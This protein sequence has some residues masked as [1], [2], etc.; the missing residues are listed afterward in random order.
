WSASGEIRIS[1]GL[2]IKWMPMNTITVMASMT[3]NA[4]TSLAS[5]W[6][7]MADLDLSAK[8]ESGQGEAPRLRRRHKLD[9]HAGLHLAGR[10]RDDPRQHGPAF[11]EEDLGEHRGRL[12]LKGGMHV[13]VHDGERHDPSPAGQGLPFQLGGPAFRAL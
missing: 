11:L 12:L 1:T 5:G 8:L 9:L 7:F 13:L 4:W 3:R 6:E 2:P 10:I